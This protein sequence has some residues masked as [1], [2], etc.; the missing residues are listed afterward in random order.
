MFLLLYKLYRPNLSVHFKMNVAFVP[1]YVPSAQ[2]S[3]APMCLLRPSVFCLCA[4]CLC[5]YYA[6][7]S[8]APMCLL[9]PSVYCAQASFAP[10]LLM[11]LLVF[12][13]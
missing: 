13:C 6:Q 9:R 10:I 12:M 2:A 3:I 1:A 4:Y 8:I 7:A 11:C 5:A